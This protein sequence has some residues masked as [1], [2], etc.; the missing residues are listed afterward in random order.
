MN[1]DGELTHQLPAFEEKLALVDIVD[2]EPMPGSIAPRLETEA[3]VYR[4]LVLGV[5]DYVR[6]NDFSG[7]LVPLC[8]GVDSALTL[9][10]AVDALGAKKVRAVMMPSHDVSS[11]TR[12]RARRLAEELAVRCT[13]L[14]I[15]GISHA[16]RAVLSA[17]SAI[18][19]GASIQD[20]LESRIRSTL[21]AALAERARALVLTSGNKSEMGMGCATYCGD[22]AGGFAVLKDVPK[23]LVYAL[24]RHRNN[25]AP[26]IPA[27]LLDGAPWADSV[28]A[29][30]DS[31]TLPPYPV[32]D[33]ILD[34]YVERQV[35][36]AEI[37]ALGHS[38]ADVRRVID[39]VCASEYRR[40]QAP[41][42]VRLTRSGFGKDGRYPITNRFRHHY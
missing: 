37:V 7:V 29:S 22:A 6:K 3:A 40:R 8:G 14:A 18:V 13:E 39:L 15:D 34:A 17:D 28:R 31:S 27:E 20:D 4:A 36:P 25:L 10:I 33:A 32:L 41:I 23:M 30:R 11:A 21:V 1:G 35:S 5:R 2:G 38:H 26:V 16:Y 19:P 24:A 12:A 42:G 9:A